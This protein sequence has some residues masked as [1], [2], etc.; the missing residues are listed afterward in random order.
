[1]RSNFRTGELYGN[2]AAESRPAE[3][4]FASVLGPI[5]RHASHP[6]STR[7]RNT[8]DVH[9]L[10]ATLPLAINRFSHSNSRISW[11]G[12]TRKL[13]KK[14]SFQGNIMAERDLPKPVVLRVIICLSY[15]IPIFFLFFLSLPP[16]FCLL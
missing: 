8:M 2:V 12:F 6:L 16:T 11:I 7:I 13:K 9:L 1:M 5:L 3:S 4:G 15:R 10:S 14:I